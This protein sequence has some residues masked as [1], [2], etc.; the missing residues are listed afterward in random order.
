MKVR[1]RFR[2]DDAAQARQRTFVR[3]AVWPFPS[4]PSPG[5]AVVIES[6]RSGEWQ[7]EQGGDITVTYPGPVEHLGARRVGSVTYI[8][9]TGE[10]FVEF[11]VEGVHDPEEQVA[12]LLRFGFREVG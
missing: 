9:M 2:L 3:D 5:D 12:A 7:V 1:Y 6:P 10:A 8:P 4:L 11:P